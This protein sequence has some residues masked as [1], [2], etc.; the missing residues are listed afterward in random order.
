MICL[1]ATALDSSKHLFAVLNAILSALLTCRVWPPTRSPLPSDTKTWILRCCNLTRKKQVQVLHKPFSL[2]ILQSFCNKSEE[3]KA[4]SLPM[5]CWVGD[6]SRRCV[7][8]HPYTCTCQGERMGMVVASSELALQ[9]DKRIH[10]V[11]PRQWHPI[12]TVFVFEYV[13]SRLSRKSD[14]L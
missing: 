9:T 5:H 1:G 3:L 12:R 6:V 13:V 2:T 8:G 10:A 14:P 11:E 7:P 4:F